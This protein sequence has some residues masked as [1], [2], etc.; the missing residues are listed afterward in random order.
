MTD[1]RIIIIIIVT[2]NN[3]H[4]YLL[5]S[6]EYIL[7]AAKIQSDYKVVEPELDYYALKDMGASYIANYCSGYPAYR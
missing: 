6:N 3:Y 2:T 1:R 5:Q 7:D 4:S